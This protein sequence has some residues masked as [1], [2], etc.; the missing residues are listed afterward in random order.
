MTPPLRTPTGFAQILT[1]AGVL[2]LLTACSPAPNA[3]APSAPTD[4]VLTFTPCMLE[5]PSG[6]SGV[7]AECATLE[8]PE[9]L[10]GQGRRIMLSI[11]RHPAISERKATDP[12]FVLAGGPGMGAQEMYTASAG[13]FARIN[14]DRDII[15][16]DQRGTG[17]STPL[18]CKVDPLLLNL[19]RP[20]PAPAAR[21]ALIDAATRECLDTLRAQHDVAQYTTSV[22]VR[23]LERVREALGAE[24]LNL[25]GVSYGSRVAQHYLRRYPDRVRSVILDGVLPP[26]LALG[27]AIATDAEAALGMI[28][29]RCAA[30]PA[31]RKAFGN[32]AD[33]YQTLRTRLAAAPRTVRLPDPRSGELRTVVFGPSQLATVLRLS[34]YSTPTAA[35]LPLAMHEAVTKDNYIPLAGALLMQLDTVPESIAIGMH[36]SVVCAED[37]PFIGEVDRARLAATYMGT[38]MIDPLRRVCA[39]WPRGPVDAG[40]RGPLKSTVPV[41]LLSG[42]ADPV[43]PPAYAEAALRGLAD[44]RHVVLQ[45][46]GHGQ[47][48]ATCMDR[49]L[50]D[51]I[52]TPA[53][54]KLDLKCLERRSAAPFFTSLAGPTP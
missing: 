7:K 35:L 37:L 18:Q 41:L 28:L 9:N 52:A 36:H 17:R 11:A 12:L 45:D 27:P 44:A 43:T 46:E 32:P 48:G 49:V 51:F 19:D 5:H 40:F 20:E 10:S 2:G 6:L 38:D 39:I 3:A 33:T 31:C 21:N 54:A 26:G 47:L 22:A 16:V 50:R 24:Q 8:V 34:S 25:Y 13:A 23:D 1:L 53:P 29:R 14:R 15:L 30:Q 42:S 4:P